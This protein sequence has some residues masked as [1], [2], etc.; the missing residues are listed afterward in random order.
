MINSVELGMFVSR[1]FI[2]FKR[3][4]TDISQLASYIRL[5]FPSS[6]SFHLFGI[7]LF[8]SYFVC[9]NVK[10][11]AFL[12][13][14][15]K[16]I[17][18]D[19]RPIRKFNG[20]R[21]S[22][23]YLL[24]YIHMPVSKF[25]YSLNSMRISQAKKCAIE[26]NAMNHTYYTKHTRTRTRYLYLRHCDS[27]NTNLKVDK[28]KLVH[29]HVDLCVW[30]VVVSLCDIHIW[31]FFFLSHLFTLLLCFSVSCYFALF[32]CFNVKKL[33]LCKFMNG[34]DPRLKNRCT[35]MINK[36]SVEFKWNWLVYNDDNDDTHLWKIVWALAR[37]LILLW[38][39]YKLVDIHFSNNISWPKK[40][41]RLTENTNWIK[42]KFY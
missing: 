23:A 1:A 9:L 12:Y 8:V 42:N 5:W 18:E 28:T 6:D 24:L 29:T 3:N 15:L 25:N 20:G 7:R 10:R 35:Q 30:F 4:L 40:E 26:L 11:C 34:K 31:T 33:P 36:L 37:A 22:V 39:F 13:G 19:K 32:C 16:Q 2:A 17:N 38:E 21:C 14:M 27:A 41:K